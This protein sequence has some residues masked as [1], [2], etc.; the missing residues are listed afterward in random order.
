VGGKRALPVGVVTLLMTD[1]GGSTRLWEERS[2]VAGAVLERHE[3]LIETRV[4]DHGGVMIRSKG[5]G[6][7]TFSVFA[8]ASGAARAAVEV[9]RAL[10]RE[11]WP[12]DAAV[13][14]RAALYTG[15]AQLREGDYYGTTPN[16]CARL[17][18][19]AH[20]GQVV[21]SQSTADGL[22]GLPAEIVR[23][24]LGLHRL[25]DVARAER[26]F[27][28]GHPELC[29][30]FPPLGTLAVRHNLPRERTRFVGRQADVTAVGKRLETDRLVTLTGIGGC[31]K[32]RLA[33]TAASGLL[34]QFPDGVFFADLAPVSDPEVVA[35][36]VA[37][38]VGFSRMSLGTGSGRPDGE[39]VE[40]LSTRQVLLVL[41]N[42]EHL[43]D[44]CAGLA[45]EILERCPDVTVLATSREAMRLP[46]EQV[47]P[48]DPLPVPGDDVSETSD[49]VQLFCE[50]A[51]AVRPDFVMSPANA[52]D[53]A[54]IC[55]RLDGIPLAIELAAAQVPHF[56]P[57]QILDR[58]G[59]RLAPFTAGR[60]E[61]A[62]R[63]SLHGAL[64]W[65]HALLGDEERA[66]F[67]RL[68]V[69]PGSFSPEA[70]LA[71]CG[72]PTALEPLLQL[73]RKS[74]IVGEDDGTDMRYRMLETVRAYAAENLLEA[75]EESLVRD[76]HRAFFLAWVESIPAELTYLDPGGAVRREQ[77]NL[78][79]ALRWSEQQGRWDLVG[80][81]A[82]TMNRV[83]IGDVREGRR[84]LTAAMDGLDDLD[85][86]HQVRVLAVAAHVAVLAIEAGDGVLARRAVAADGRPGVWSSLAHGLLCLNHGLRGFV[87]KDEHDAAEV[88]RLGRKAVELAPEPLSRGLAWFW[89]GQA[90]VLLDDLDGAADALERGSPEAVRGG[91][92]AVVSLALLAGVHHLRGEHEAAMAAATE[93]VDRAQSYRRSGLWAWELYT[94]LPY[95]L[96]LGNH[97][98]H[99]EALDFVHDMLD[100]NAVPETPGV[101][102]SVVT[103]LAALA[104]MRGDQETAGVLL[105]YAGQAIMTTGIRTPVD[106]ALY[107]HYL[108]RYGEVD[109]E[110]A[111]RNSEQAAAMSV[112]DAVARGLGGG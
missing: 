26:V 6:D 24:D 42:C 31:G 54:E 103:V 27:Q 63:R 89:L 85:P 34:E 62:R 16:R 95:A 3:A 104:V 91:D 13:R 48:V 15:E 37:A 20:P 77:H 30:D 75:G 102:T 50:R 51:A 112:S 38:A 65:S 109:A 68:A 41:D 39:L 10:Q 43:M 60:R 100:D 14:V 94:S 9:Q 72:E 110:I 47:H 58:L 52:S 79:A 32:T 70:A 8:D 44:A 80:R 111:R 7:S 49:A 11:P 64:D 86:E 93:V 25:R 69:F 23:T 55:R 1:V 92:M 84:W 12:D 90:R 76:R 107:S 22:D 66:V 74:L 97:G 46:G 98:R 28:L 71:V 18:A 108:R 40:F 4:L 78:R 36:A 21:C 53:I 81:L 2:D 87:G 73:R 96:E 19:A 29:A 105:A 35:G 59:D 82:S 17:R 101:M 61:P 45:D 56:S 106:L 88:E 99:A 5:E 83:W 33:I 57:C 67:R